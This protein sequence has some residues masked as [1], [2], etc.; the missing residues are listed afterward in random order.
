VINPSGTFLDKARESL[1]GARLAYQGGRYN[2]TANRSY[3]A[4]LQAAIHALVIAQVRPPGSDT[5]GETKWNHGFVQGQFNGLL[6]NRRH[7]YSPD[8]RTVLTVNY[9]LR[10]DADYTRPGHNSWL[11]DQAAFRKALRPTRRFWPCWKRWSKA[12]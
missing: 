3:Y 10:V 2:N 11:P 9:E 1:E 4:C 7:R 6:I 12:T 5:R 8:L